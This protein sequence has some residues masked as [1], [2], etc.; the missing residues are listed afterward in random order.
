MPAAFGAL[1][2]NGTAPLVAA[3]SALPCMPAAFGALHMNG[4]AP[5]VAAIRAANT[6]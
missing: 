6:A 5:L 1:H 3:T 4:T 2:M